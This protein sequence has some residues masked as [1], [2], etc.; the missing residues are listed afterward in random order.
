MGSSQH[1]GLHVYAHRV[2]VEVDNLLEMVHA[3]QR[4]GVSGYVQYT[5]QGRTLKFVK[6][7]RRPDQL[8]NVTQSGEGLRII[9]AYRGK[10]IFVD[11][12]NVVNPTMKLLRAPFQTH[13]PP[14]GPR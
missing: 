3:R 13:E 1:I 4:E 6:I 5:M 12:G 8:G 7:G 11:L 9:M 10:T 14:R 2:Y